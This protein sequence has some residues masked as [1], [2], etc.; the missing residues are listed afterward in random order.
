MSAT[1]E[2]TAKI[3]AERIGITK[4]RI[5]DNISKLQKRNGMPGIPTYLREVKFL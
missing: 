2:I 1:P 4:R 5:E 3:L